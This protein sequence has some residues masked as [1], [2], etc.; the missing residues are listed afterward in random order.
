MLSL[1]KSFDADEVSRIVELA[2]KINNLNDHLQ[3]LLDRNGALLIS[4]NFDRSAINYTSESIKQTMEYL[5]EDK[6]E[7]LNLFSGLFL[8]LNMH[9]EWAAIKLGIDIMNQWKA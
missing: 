2:E 5:E 1:S 7:L 3:N 6:R 9:K 8:S 4:G